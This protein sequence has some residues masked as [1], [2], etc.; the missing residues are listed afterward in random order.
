MSTFENTVM[1]DIFSWIKKEPT[2]IGLDFD[3]TLVELCTDPKQVRL[4]EDQAGL[5]EKLGKLTECAVISGRGLKDL[6][7]Y[8]C[9]ENLHLIGNHGC[10]LRLKTGGQKVWSSQNWQQWRLE[11]LEVLK[12]LVEENQGRLEDKHY[13]LAVHYREAGNQQWWK[14]RALEELRRTVGD[15][16]LVLDGISALN[17]V[18]QAAPHK[19]EAAS[20]LC[21]TLNCQ[22]LLY[23]GDE[24]TDENVFR[25]ASVPTLGVKV[26]AGQTH[27][28]LRVDSS[29]DVWVLLNGILSKLQN[30]G[31]IF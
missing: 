26:G 17:I 7:T 5:L 15:Q 23:F 27:A 30:T 3:G 13:S 20:E 25:Y 12:R 4:R 19:G 14:T 2:L 8:A 29:Q 22:R 11:R 10:E 18:P 1:T 9:L 31:R 21:R 24:P 6:R 28:K 16:A